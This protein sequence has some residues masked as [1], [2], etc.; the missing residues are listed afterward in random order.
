MTE[1]R[2]ILVGEQ[3][4][5]KCSIFLFCFGLYFFGLY[6]YFADI[7]PQF[8]TKPPMHRGENLDISSTF[9]PIIFITMIKKKKKK[10]KPLE[11]YIYM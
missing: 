1:K 6:F 3:K 10:K 2:A 5:G 11:E 7:H 4:F 9:S 8:Q